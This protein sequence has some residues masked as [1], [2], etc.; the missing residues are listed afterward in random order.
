[1][2]VHT[3][4]T[5]DQQQE[6]E[7]GKM[8]LRNKLLLGGIGLTGVAGYSYIKGVADGLS[9]A[10]FNS[11]ETKRAKRYRQAQRNEYKH[12]NQSINRIKREG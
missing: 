4:L 7:G 11:A 12:I 2:Q 6:G 10:N 9:I 3:L 8:K 5:E 1:M